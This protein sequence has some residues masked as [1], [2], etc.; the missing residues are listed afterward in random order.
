[1]KSKYPLKKLILLNFWLS[2]Y[3][4]LFG[5]VTILATSGVSQIHKAVLDSFIESIILIINGLMNLLLLLYF[6]NKVITR[7]SKLWKRQ[8]V[9]SYL[10]SFLI[11]VVIIFGFAAI[12]GT[13]VQI[14]TLLLVAIICILINSLILVLQNYLIIQD[15]KAGADMENMQLKAANADAANQ[16]LRQQIHPHF[17]FNTLNIL[18]SLYKINPSAGE[19]Y[20]VHL[21]DFLR[22]A[23]S[24]NNIKVI[25][26][27]DELKL[28]IDYLEMQKI[29]FGKA[30]MYTIS[31]PGDDSG[32]VP[33][34]SIHPLVENSIKH[35]GFTEE[36]PLHIKIIKEGDRITVLNNLKLK[37]SSEGSTGSGLTNLSERYRII[38]GDEL[39]IKQTPGIFSASIKI[40]QHEYSNN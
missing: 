14:S 17:L 19:E 29:R 10:L 15:A 32:Y 30:L 33:S 27:K 34:F 8:M 25:P 13:E 9:A 21:S 4:F 35:N 23:V 11:Y 36:Y 18:K 7:K 5:F 12:R 39:I 31:V 22:A 38:S 3:F 26:L 2:S 37:F 6:E 28:C 40:L 16:L 1:M 24:T 20:L